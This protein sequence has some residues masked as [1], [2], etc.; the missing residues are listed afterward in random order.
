MEPLFINTIVYDK[1]TLKETYRH[2]CFTRLS[3]RVLSALMLLIL[4]LQSI[5][6][7]FSKDYLTLSLT[8]LLVLAFVILVIL[9]YVSSVRAALGRQKETGTDTPQVEF[10]VT[11]SEICSLGSRGTRTT[12]AFADIR[13]VSQTQHLICLWTR[14]NQLVTLSK[15]AFSCGTYED[16][17]AFLRAKGYKVR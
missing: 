4:V 10:T 8:A 5:F 12:I 16:F 13:R 3:T 1:D 7:V 14:A 6:T 15:T 9:Q 2:A 11:E 17:L